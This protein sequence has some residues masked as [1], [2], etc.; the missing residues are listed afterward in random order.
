MDKGQ[1]SSIFKFCILILFISSIFE[2][3]TIYFI[4]LKSPLTINV[5]ESIEIVIIPFSL[6]IRLKVPVFAPR[7][8][9]FFGLI[10]FMK[11]ATI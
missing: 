3:S 8:H 6:E 11:S 4:I 1:N 7:S 2:S 10:L 5:S 9:T